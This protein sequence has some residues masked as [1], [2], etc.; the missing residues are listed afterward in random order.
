MAEEIVSG[1]IVFEA[2]YPG[3]AFIVIVDALLFLGPLCIFAQKLW[4]CRVKGMSDY[5]AFA[6]R[7]V[8][9]FDRK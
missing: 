9:D 1:K 4:A 7:Y 3:L 6:A 8:D 2:I 5:M